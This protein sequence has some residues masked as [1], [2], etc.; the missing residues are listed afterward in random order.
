MSDC[1]QLRDPM[2]AG[3]MPSI[4]DHQVFRVIGRGAFGE[5]WLARNVMGIWRAVKVVRRSTFSGVEPYDRE[6]QAIE[7]Y[8]PVARSTDGLVQVLHVGRHDNEGYFYYVMELADPASDEPAAEES[9]RT[10]S[11]MAATPGDLSPDAYRPHTLSSELP[12]GERLNLRRVLAISTDLV[13]G[14]TQLHGHGLVHRDVKPSNVIFVHGRAR[15]ADVGLVD[16][17]GPPSFA[18]TDGYVAPEGTGTPAAD[19]YS[20]GLIL[21]EMATGCDRKQYPRLPESWLL[22]PDPTWCELHEV[23][24]RACEGIPERRYQSAAEMEADLAAISSGQSIRER[25]ALAVR[26]R[27]IRLAG[28][29]ATIGVVAALGWG[30][31]S[32]QRA[33]L[34]HRAR[35]QADRLRAETQLALVESRLAQASANRQTGRTG[36]RFETLA[37]IVEAVNRLHALSTNSVA[38]VSSGQYAKLMAMARNEAVAALTRVDLREIG[39]W[40]ATFDRQWDL[41][42]DEE[43]QHLAVIGPSNTVRILSIPG[44]SVE[45]SL[46][47]GPAAVRFLGPFSP[48]GRRLMVRYTTGETWVWNLDSLRVVLRQADFGRH[49]RPVFWRQ[50]ILTPRAGGGLEWVSLKD[51]SVIHRYPTAEQLMWLTPSRDGGRVLG[52]SRWFAKAYLLRGAALR[53]EQCRPLPRGVEMGEFALSP[54]GQYLAATV[55]IGPVPLLDLLDPQ[56]PS[57]QL[58]GHSAEVVAAGFHPEG[59]YLATSSWDGTLRIWDWHSGE[60]Q[61][62]HDGWTSALRFS[63]DGSRC[64]MVADGAEQPEIVLLECGTPRFLARWRPEAAGRD[65]KKIPVHAAFSPDSRSLAVTTTDGVQVLGLPRLSPQGRCGDDEIYAVRFAPGRNRLYL[66]GLK[67]GEVWD[68]TAGFDSGADEG[69]ASWV[70]RKGIADDPPGRSLQSAGD[71]LR[72][73][74]LGTDGT[75][76]AV[77]RGTRVLY[78]GSGS[79]KWRPLQAFGE[80]EWMTTSANGTWM[81]VS[82][83]DR[84]RVIRLADEVQ[85]W[86]TTVRGVPRFAFSPD[87]DRLAVLDADGLRCAGGSTGRVLWH[88]PRSDVSLRGGEISWSVDGR[89]I[90]AALARRDV[91]LVDAGSG[92]VVVRVTSPSPAAVTTANLS[93]DDRYLAVTLDDQSIQL[94]NLEELHKELAGLGLAWADP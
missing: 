29:L 41:P 51:P 47:S 30:A 37:R 24:L 8:E 28:T 65:G 45:C 59:Q 67:G 12:G 86:S 55:L 70:A 54:D 3:G 46:P 44:T 88:R 72:A 83:G 49:L 74:T 39:R 42:L 32:R 60:V 73:L 25:R 75:P 23:I 91:S 93:P 20:L 90:A 94:W 57:R 63:A 78:R 16:T 56:S 15:L 36:Q 17:Q 87:N 80:Q 22:D 68:L 2:M 61:L 1:A 58:T 14:L 13:R 82:I 40:P 9:G 19:L 4:P 50:G 34:E 31:A 89:R 5:V 71:N 81:A 62:I 35:L 77:L 85:A 10:L 92:D 84:L 53:Q 69:G 52:F 43:L 21:Y 26:A 27:R 76:L 64:A 7:Q 11:S 48:D 33:S 66:G 79:G 18:G 6:F 38:P